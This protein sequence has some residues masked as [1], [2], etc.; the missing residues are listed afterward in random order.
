MKF[1]NYFCKASEIL[2]FNRKLNAQEA[3]ERNLVNLVFPHDQMEELFKQ[4]LEEYS[5][6]NCHV[7]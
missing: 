2:L 4:K 3:F 6:L 7:K 5:K 1:S